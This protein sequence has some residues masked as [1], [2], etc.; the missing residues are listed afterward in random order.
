MQWRAL[1]I[2]LIPSFF[3]CIA[4]AEETDT[5][6]DEIF[7]EDD[8][9]DDVHI[10]PD[11]DDTTS[12]DT[13]IEEDPAP[14]R[15]TDTDEPPPA[16][17]ARD[18]TESEAP[19]HDWSPFRADAEVDGRWDPPADETPPPERK[20]PTEQ[21]IPAPE[22][23]V[24]RPDPCAVVTCSGRGD[25][26]VVSGNPTCACHAGFMPDSVNG[27]SCIPV[28]PAS[29]GPDPFDRKA[30]DQRLEKTLGDDLG[31]IRD[32]YDRAVAD[33]RFRG[34]FVKYL[35]RRLRRLK[36]NGIILFSGGVA[37]LFSGVALHVAYGS[38][39]KNAQITGAVALDLIGASL[40][41]AGA[42]MM[43]RN[44]QRL[45]R[46]EA[47]DRSPRH[48]RAPRLQPGVWRTAK[49]AGVDWRILF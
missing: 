40:M 4:D 32:A 13:A 45:R 36:R 25:C 14:T 20:A 5:D 16:L 34:D 43:V 47:F 48:T 23:D 41:G 18:T 1:S 6:V 31:P 37:G 7:T 49:G 10:A 21:P 3:P 9:A 22:A 24:P 38:S 35:D 12:D 42:A 15:D 8:V 19:Q 26:T 46:L 33:G 17:P 30:Y 44:E 29:S 39:R 11:T 27:L 28:R 2:I